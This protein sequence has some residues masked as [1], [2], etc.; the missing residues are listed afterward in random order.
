MFLLRNN[1]LNVFSVN[2]ITC[3]ALSCP[4]GSVMTGIA[5]GS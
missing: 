1:K 2:L 3:S 4:N 5:L